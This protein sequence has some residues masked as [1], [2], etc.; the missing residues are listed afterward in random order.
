MFGGFGSAFGS[1]L[2]DVW[3][4]IWVE[5]GWLDLCPVVVICSDGFGG[6][7]RCLLGLFGGGFRC[8]LGLFGGEDDDDNDEEELV[9]AKGFGKLEL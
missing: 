8:L 3:V 4:S 7:F 2:G 5:I 9:R 6:G 1:D